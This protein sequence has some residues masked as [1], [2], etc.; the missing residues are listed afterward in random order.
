MSTTTTLATIF[1]ELHRLRRH[2]K[3]LQDMVERGPRILKAHQVKVV[4]QEEALHEAQEALKRLKVA[5]HEKEVSLKVT[6]QQ[7]AKY[8]EQRNKA[9][10][11]K[12]YDTLQAEIAA[13]RQSA[14]KIEDDILEG[15]AKIEEEAAQ[16]PEAEKALQQA[17]QDHAA[18][19]QQTQERLAGQR[20]Q[21]AQV[22]EKI[23]EVE[24]SLPS[25]VRPVYERLV[26]ARGEEALAVAASQTCSACHTGMTAQQQH[27]LLAGRLVLC[28]SCG[29]I[30]YLPELADGGQGGQE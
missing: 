7:I 15:M 22:L 24:T 29:R 20:E 8:E 10:T 6:H 23:K 30:L 25:E 2:A 17:K 1:R 11:R 19:E 9:T 18:F 14:R 26:Q 5:N 4:K 27:D 28:K 21:H 3:D 16:V 13:G 12:E